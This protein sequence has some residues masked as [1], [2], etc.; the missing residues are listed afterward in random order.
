MFFFFYS[1]TYKPGILLNIIKVLWK[2]SFHQNTLFY[3]MHPCE[4]IH[5][6]LMRWSEVHLSRIGSVGL[7]NFII[8]L[9]LY[10]NFTLIHFLSGI[11][12]LI[13][14]DCGW[15]WVTETMEKET[16]DKGQL[17]CSLTPC[18]TW[19]SGAE[20]TPKHLGSSTITALL[21]ATSVSVPHRSLPPAPL[22]GWCFMQWVLCSGAS[23]VAPYTRL[24]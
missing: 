19:T 1:W 15:K 14:F 12:N 7:H 9:L 5:R 24:P 20:C 22:P 13:P 23:A 4:V 6:Y 11:F 18:F 2:Y 8:L 10:C 21:S 17:A 16:V 3:C